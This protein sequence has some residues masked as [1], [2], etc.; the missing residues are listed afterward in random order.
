MTRIPAL[1]AACATLFALP[2]LAAPS[3]TLS[4]NPTSAISPASVTLTWTST[5]TSS[6]TASGAWS[7]VKAVNGSEIVSNL[8]A[9]ASFTLTCASTGR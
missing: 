2:A 6:C 4:A 1:I 9:D 5:E 3:V 7:G 8:R